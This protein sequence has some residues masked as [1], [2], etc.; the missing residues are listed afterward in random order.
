MN[1]IIELA[2]SDKARKTIYPTP[3]ALAERLLSGLDW[4]KIESVLEPSAGKGDLARYCAGQIFY[5]R[6]RY[7]AHDTHDW[8]QAI[9][10]ADI[11]C[12]EIDPMLRNTLDG[13][14]FRVV[15]DDFLPTKPRSAIT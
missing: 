15:H 14:G 12:I 5:S 9:R 1:S 6:H 3:E 2:S 4:R 13:S 7:P 10:E 8:K 11:D